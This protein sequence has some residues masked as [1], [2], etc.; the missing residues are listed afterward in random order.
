MNGITF[1]RVDDG[2]YGTGLIAQD[3]EVAAAGLVESKAIKLHAD[4]QKLTDIKTVNYSSIPYMLINAVKQLYVNWSKDHDV[5]A[6][7][8]REIVSLRT[9][10]DLKSQKIESLEA[11]LTRIEK[12]LDRKP[13]GR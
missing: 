4:D 3:V 8:Q 13:A 12:A 1:K 7:Q 11:R 9:E 10:S 6:R 2:T 5:I